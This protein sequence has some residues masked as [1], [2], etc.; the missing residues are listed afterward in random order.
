MMVSKSKPTLFLLACTFLAFSSVVVDAFQAS[1]PWSDAAARTTKRRSMRTVVGRTVP[2][3][4]APGCSSAT[5]SSSSSEGNTEQASGGAAAGGGA[6]DNKAM[7]FLKKMGKV[8]G[9]AN[10]D[11]RY[12]IGVDEGT[13]GKSAGSG[14]GMQ[15]TKAAFGSCVQTGVVDDMS[16][17][18]PQ[19][20]SGT[21]WSGFT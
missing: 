16:E 4:P 18:F 15:K 19:T 9:A 2:R 8:G 6:G 11:F 5:R 14:G 10:R 12:A 1:S 13:S 20:S 17:D 3:A 21:R 7:Q